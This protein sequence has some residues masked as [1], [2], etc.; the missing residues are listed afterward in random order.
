M[1]RGHHFFSV[2]VQLPDGRQLPDAQRSVLERMRSLL[3]AEADIQA[4]NAVAAAAAA[5]AAV[6]AA[7]EALAGEAARVA[8]DIAACGAADAT[9]ASDSQQHRDPKW[10]QRQSQDTGLSDALG[11][12]REASSQED[13]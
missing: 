10:R 12:R 6:V 3:L 11:L 5:M 1:E 7:E 4:A 2:R 9:A 13:T 8:A